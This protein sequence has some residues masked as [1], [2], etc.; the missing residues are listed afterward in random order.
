MLNDPSQYAEQLDV[1]AE[2][3]WRREL[4]T[5]KIMTKI[6]FYICEQKYQLF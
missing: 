1:V 2:K 5:L 4:H 6:I 3:S